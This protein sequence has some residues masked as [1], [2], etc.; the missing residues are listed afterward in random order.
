ML[1]PSVGAKFQSHAAPNNQK[2]NGRTDDTSAQRRRR[3]QRRS[4]PSVDVSHT[5]NCPSAAYA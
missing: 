5:V 4:L 1:A 3:S 2:P